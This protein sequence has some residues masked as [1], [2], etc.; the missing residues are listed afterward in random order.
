MKKKFLKIFS[1]LIFNKFLIN[2]SLNI[3][4]LLN[5][6]IYSRNFLNKFFYRILQIYYD[7]ITDPENYR[8][9]NKKLYIIKGKK[10]SDLIKKKYLLNMPNTGEHYDH[11]HILKIN[12]YDI[13]K[14]MYKSFHFREVF[15]C[16][17]YIKLIE[18]SNHLGEIL[19]AQLGSASGHDLIW[20][21]KNT[22]I[23]NLISTD[24]SQ[25]ALDFQKKNIFKQDF[26]MNKNDEIKVEFA[27][28]SCLE[29]SEYLI[30]PKFQD[31]IKVVFGKGSLQYETPENVIIFFNN[32]SNIKN[33]YL[34]I[35]QPLKSNFLAFSNANFLSSYRGQFSFNHNYKII[36]EK[37]GMRTIKYSSVDCDGVSNINL[38]AKSE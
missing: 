38:L 27:K 6:Q 10:F 28:M 8:F 14:I 16:Y 30:D 35:S 15:K 5:Y 32:I 23:K 33:L 24:I 1:F 36:S 12:N 4:K 2:I 26:I 17:E 19:L 22:G 13:S 3:I 37:S 9:I 11:K 31:K 29:L 25:E 20:V 7:K 18:G 21:L 34:S